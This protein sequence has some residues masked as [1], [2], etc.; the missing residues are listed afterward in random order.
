MAHHAGKRSDRFA[1]GRTTQDVVGG[2]RVDELDKRGLLDGIGPHGPG[3]A[4]DDLATLVEK[5]GYANL[6]LHE[7]DLFETLPA[8]LRQNPAT[9]V[10]LLHLDLDVYEPT[11]FAL[12]AL[13]PHMV[14]GGL[15]VLDDYGLVKGATK[16][17]DELCE[18]RNLELRKLSNYQIPAYIVMP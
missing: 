12:E 1:I 15:I 3:I 4:K 2:E 14:K 18:A 6:E 7:G 5:K 9:K 13:A 11:A 10:A 17:A 16:A 8:F